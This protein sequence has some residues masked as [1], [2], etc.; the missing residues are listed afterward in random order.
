MSETKIICP[1][2]GNEVEL[3][4]GRAYEVGDIIECPYC[5]SE[6]EVVANE[7]GIEIELIEEEK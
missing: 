7:N 4:E 1:E 5:G 3:E 6:L 2:C